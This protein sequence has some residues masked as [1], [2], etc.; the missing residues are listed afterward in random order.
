MERK[1]IEQLTFPYKGHFTTDEGA[2]VYFTYQGRLE[3]D[4]L[5]FSATTNERENIIIKFTKRYSENAHRHCSGQGAAPRLY[6]F[7]ALPGGWFMVVMENLSSS[8]K[9][10]HQHDQI[11]SEMSD[12]LQKAVGILHDGNFVHGDVRDVNLM[13]PEEGGVG[14]FMIL[15]FDWAGFEGEVRYPAYVNIV[16]VS[17]PKG[18]IDGE[19]ITKQHDLDM[20]DRIIHR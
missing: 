13:V 15:D 3:N 18:A 11:S 6:A 1:D 14:N 8:H 9:L 16:G 4:K 20:L 12:A 17:R 5:L 7:N 2:K 19:L 10:V